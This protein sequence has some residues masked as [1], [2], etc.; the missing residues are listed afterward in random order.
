[1]LP[2]LPD[3][4]F[5]TFLFYFAQVSNLTHT[6]THTACPLES[7]L[8]RFLRQLTSVSAQMLKL[9]GHAQIPARPKT[10]HE[11]LSLLCLSA[12]LGGSLPNPGNH[13]LLIILL[14]PAHI[15]AINFPKFHNIYGFSGGSDGKESACLQETQ[16]QSLDWE[17]PLEKEMA[18][19]SSIL[20]WRITLTEE[21]GG[22]QSMGLPR[23]GHDWV[24]NTFTFIIM[25][26]LAQNQH[27]LAF[28]HW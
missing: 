1:M 22:L 19:H 2:K 4:I 24:T 23:V 12:D 9:R 6:H 20:A 26:Y 11:G 13:F 7:L 27:W 14:H 16:I 25:S 15:W 5:E 28:V 18:T 8:S 10:P 21:P 3:N 17:D